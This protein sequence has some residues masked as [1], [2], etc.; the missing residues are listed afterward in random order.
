MITIQHWTPMNIFTNG[1]I[2]ENDALNYLINTVRNSDKDYH[3]MLKFSGDDILFCI[4]EGCLAFR[5]R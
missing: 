3:I 4:D 2:Y 1:F 5:Q